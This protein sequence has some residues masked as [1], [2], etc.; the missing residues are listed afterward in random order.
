MFSWIC[1]HG[2]LACLNDVNIL[3][4]WT[5]CSSVLHRCKCCENITAARK[6]CY[7]RQR[8]WKYP[9]WHE[10]CGK[11]SLITKICLWKIRK[12]NH[13]IDTNDNTTNFCGYSENFFTWK[14]RLIVMN[15]FCF[16]NARWRW[17]NLWNF[18]RII[19]PQ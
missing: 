4:W 3:K 14:F 15:I 1:W 2:K 9:I 19:Q 17:L 7:G 16:R 18:N 5:H 6:V 12:K 11:M 10:K 8:A 13:V